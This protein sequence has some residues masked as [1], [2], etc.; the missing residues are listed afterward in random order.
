MSELK[1]GGKV[2]ITRGDGYFELGEI[3]TILTVDP[4]DSYLPIEGENSEGEQSWLYPTEFEV[5][6]EDAVVLR[7]SDLPPV[8]RLEGLDDV[9]VNGFPTSRRETDNA[10]AFS[11]RVIAAHRHYAANPKPEDP[12][13][14][15]ARVMAG[16]SDTNPLEIAKILPAARRLIEAYDFEPKA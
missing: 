9:M 14:E 8:Q 1:V 13:M 4:D 12:A 10:L 3:L 11:L 5:V 7:E 16:G 15:L 2:R 6:T